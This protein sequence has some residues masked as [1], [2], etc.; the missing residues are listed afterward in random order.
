[1]DAVLERLVDPEMHLVQLLAPP[2]D[3][4]PHDPG[5]IKAY[6]PGV[7]EN[8]G[9]YTHA[10]LW[11]VWAFVHLGKGGVASD[12]FRMLN[13]IY[14]SDT[15]EKM[16]LYMVEPYV[17]A[18]DVYSA[19]PYAGRGGWTWY[20]G[21]SGWMY[22]VGVEAILGIQRAGNL[23]RIKPCIPQDWNEYRVR[24]RFGKTSY[25]IHVQNPDH[26]SSGVK[27]LILDDEILTEREILL[28]DDRRKHELLVKMGAR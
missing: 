12:L 28:A 4:T 21:S 1:M 17:V 9:Q 10:A 22:R 3:K 25:H 11:C 26:V 20:T 19:R 27:E 8:G 2:F 16:R 5:Y 18:A 6:P 14:H 15:P 23:L 7:R 13:P 24:Y